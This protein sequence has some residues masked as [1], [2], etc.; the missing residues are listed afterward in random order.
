MGRKCLTLAVLPNAPGLIYPGKNQQRLLNKRNRLLKK[1]QEENI[2]DDITYNLALEE[3]LPQQP[4]PHSA[5]GF[6]FI[7]THC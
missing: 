7:A 3:P 1:L 6:A 5:N 2:I 4:F